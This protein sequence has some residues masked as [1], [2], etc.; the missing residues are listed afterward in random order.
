[1]KYS[2]N[3]SPCRLGALN[4]AIHFHDVLDIKGIFNV[5]I[6]GEGLEPGDL[7]GCTVDDITLSRG[8]ESILKG[9]GNICDT[10][11]EVRSGSNGNKEAEGVGI[12]GRGGKLVIG[13]R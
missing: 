2:V 13:S 4:F 7:M 1:M 3:L 11:G 9:I 5:D 6:W 10:N 8:L 12:K